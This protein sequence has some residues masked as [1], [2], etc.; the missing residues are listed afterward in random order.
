MLTDNPPKLLLGENQA[1]LDHFAG[2]A[3]VAYANSVHYQGI[4]RDRLA[5]SCY[6]TAEAMM[7]ERAKRYQA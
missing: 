3:L 7:A 6:E 4:S 1:L 5:R 2:Q